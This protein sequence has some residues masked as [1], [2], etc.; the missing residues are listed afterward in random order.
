MLYVT[1]V[2]AE[3]LTL[4]VLFMLTSALEVMLVGSVVLEFVVL[5]S[6]PPATLAGLVR[7][8]TPVPPAAVWST[9][10]GTVMTV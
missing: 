8:L 1:L 5:V 2:P 3:A 9:V 10:T 7:L 6:P 4:P